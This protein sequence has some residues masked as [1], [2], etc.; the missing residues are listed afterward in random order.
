MT[1]RQKY[2]IQVMR[3]LAIIGVVFL[4]CTPGGLPSVYLRPLVNFCVGMF[5]FLSGLLSDAEHWK[6]VKRIVKVLIPYVIW[7]FIFTAQTAWMDADGP[8]PDFAGIA[9]LLKDPAGFVQGIATALQTWWSGFIGETFTDD[10]IFNLITAKAA[11]PMYFIFV[12]IQFTL[13]IPLIDVLAKSRLKYLGF[14]I[15]PCEIIFLRL[16]PLIRGTEFSETVNIILAFSCLG[17]FTY[18]YLGYLL[19]NSIISLNVNKIFLAVLIVISLAVQTA[20]GYWYFTQ[21]FPNVGTQLKLSAIISGTLIC[22]AAY[23]YIYSPGRQSRKKR[24]IPASFLKIVGDCSF[25]IYFTHIFVLRI[26]KE[27]GVIPETLS[28]PVDA[29]VITLISLAL[30]FAAQKITSPFRRTHSRAGSH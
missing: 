30:V 14:L 2:N 13:L 23:E 11:V 5:I 3:G 9:P 1:E 10:Y 15:A 25:G 28:Y 7:S 26:L 27:L 17:W 8:M 20:E 6:P 16:M 12:Y 4:H 21:G 19:G 18:F 24:S 29:V 22:I